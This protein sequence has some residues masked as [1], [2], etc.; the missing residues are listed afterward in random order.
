MVTILSFDI[1]IKNLAYCLFEYNNVNDFDIFEWNIIDIRDGKVKSTLYEQSDFLLKSLD[2]LFS[3]KSIDYVL[4]ENQPVLKNPT[5]KTI[6]IIIYTYFRNLKINCEKKITDIV[7]VNANNKG[8]FVEMLS[9]STEIGLHFIIPSS[10]DIP[11]RYKRTKQISIIATQKLLDKQLVRSMHT[12]RDCVK[13]F[14]ECKK[15]DDLSDTLL[16]GLYF[17]NKVLR[18]E[19]T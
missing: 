16:Q 4:I 17:C 6:Q 13:F 3:L 15:K 7:L 12:Y 10:E 5:M 19:F 18:F 11:N 2:N 1:G 14:E 9:S 8:K